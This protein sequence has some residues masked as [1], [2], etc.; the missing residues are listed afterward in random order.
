MKLMLVGGH[1]SPA[2]AIL[3][4]LPKDTK[5]VFVGRKYALEGDKAFSLE[6]ATITKLGIDFCGTTAGRLQRKFTLWTIPSLLKLPLGFIHSFFILKRFKPDVVLG[7]GGYISVPIG[8]M[9]GFLRIPLIIHEQAIEG[10]L[11]NKILSRFALRICISWEETRLVFPK[12]KTILTGLPIRKF[13]NRRLWKRF[14]K[15]TNLPLIYITGGSL[16]SHFINSLVEN[17]LKGLLKDFRV[18]HQTGDTKEYADFERLNNLKNS[19]PQKFKDRYILQKFVEP[20]DVGGILREA[21][22][23]VSRSG[24]NTIAEL[25]LFKNPAI[26]VPLPFLKEQITNGL[27]FKKLGGGEIRFQ[28]DL[29]PSS[30][31]QTLHEMFGSLDVYRKNLEKS[32]LIKENAAQNIVQV[33]SDVLDKKK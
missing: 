15:D 3:D 13:S 22:L 8:I 4:V 33:I 29:A 20:S 31:L 7:F 1:L 5:I 32:S 25:I 19:L 12:E 26:L 10:G 14:W 24:I 16:G 21:D 2:L 23:V 28:K 18:V 11:A 6:Y 9:A 27:L 17:S 30:F